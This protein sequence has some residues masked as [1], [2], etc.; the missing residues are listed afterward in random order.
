MPEQPVRPSRDV[1]AYQAYLKG[2]YYWNKPGDEGL[3]QAIFYFDQARESDPEFAAAYAD[4][5]RARPP[6]PEY[7]TVVP[8]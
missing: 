7:Y 6:A 3:D 5:A 8:A 2:R 1:A 4:L